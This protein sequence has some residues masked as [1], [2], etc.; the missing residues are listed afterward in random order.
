VPGSEDISPDMHHVGS[1]GEFELDVCKIVKVDGRDVG[2][3]RTE[4]GVYAIANRCPHMGG[5]ICYG[6]V[7]GLMTGTSP[8][9]IAYDETRKAMRCPWHG[10][11]FFLSDGTSVGGI[12]NRR[13]RR[14]PLQV[15]QDEVY[16]FMRM[17]R[18]GQ[19]RTPRA[20]ADEQAG[21]V[22]LD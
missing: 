7:T 5:G 20:D 6:T 19:A 10:W 2:V 8:E 12:T 22:E 16:V 1:L 9:N 14:F 21:S 13:L 18:P 4:Q 3:V 11:E 15:I 17:P